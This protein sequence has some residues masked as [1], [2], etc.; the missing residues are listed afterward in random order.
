MVILP[1]LI[2]I[3]IANKVHAHE[4]S[5]E[6]WFLVN[7]EAVLEINPSP[8]ASK[9]ENPEHIIRGSFDANENI[10]FKINREVLGYESNIET[11]WIVGK[12]MFT[13]DEFIYSFPA[14]GSFVITLEF[15]DTQKEEIFNEDEILI[16]IGDQQV[17]QSFSINGQ[18]ID[19]SE[20]LQIVEVSRSQNTSLTVLNSDANKYLYQWDYSDGVIVEDTEA[21]VNFANVRLPA[22]VILRSINKETNVWADTFVRIESSEN[23]EFEVQM[24]AAPTQDA[25]KESEDRSNLVIYSVLVVGVVVLVLFG[26]MWNVMKRRENTS[27]NI[28]KQ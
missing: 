14:T 25:I 2:L 19:S 15:F 28:E 11:R 16:H 21:S 17:G 5:E 23:Q 9:L 13:G 18:T 7:D 27:S 12:V 4:I 3:D 6:E 8:F 20:D 22:Y 24:P 26:I 1:S 10:N